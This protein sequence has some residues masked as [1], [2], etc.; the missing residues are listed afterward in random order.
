VGE[1]FK[2]RI[3]RIMSVAFASSPDYKR[4]IS[5]S[6]D[7]T[8]RIWD[9]E[10]VGK[11]FE[12]PLHWDAA[13]DGT[14]RIWDTETGKPITNSIEGPT[15]RVMPVALSNGTVQIWDAET[16]RLVRKPWHTDLVHSVAFLPDGRCVV[17]GSN[18]ST[19]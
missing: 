16:G 10:M 6:S 5:G 2:E 4:L 18:D 12:V 7:G 3:G 9:A 14:V 1:S 19:D 13:S 11:S 8:V 17:S 15:D